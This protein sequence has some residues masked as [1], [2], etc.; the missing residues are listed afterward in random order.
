MARYTT[1][2]DFQTPNL[3][4]VQYFS[5]AVE[6]LPTLGI[7]P[8]NIHFDS[9]TLGSDRYICIRESRDEKNTVAI[10]NTTN[11]SNILRRAVTAD[12]IALHPEGKIL[13]L[14]GTVFLI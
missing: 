10:V 14:G 13:A 6:Q 8:A 9:L 4:Y 1:Q 3:L 7:T 11:T 12:T 2:G 5:G